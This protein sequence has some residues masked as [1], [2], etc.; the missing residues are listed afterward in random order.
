MGQFI[1]KQQFASK[2]MKQI[3]NSELAAVEQAG[4]IT[5]GTHSHIVLQEIQTNI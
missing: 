2:N 3:Y 4:T 1:T 5:Q